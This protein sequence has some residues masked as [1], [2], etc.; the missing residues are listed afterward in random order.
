MA[1]SVRIAPSAGL[2]ILQRRG[3]CA[4]TIPATEPAPRPRR[5]VDS[6][7]WAGFAKRMCNE[8]VVD[9]V[10]G[11]WVW[12]RLGM[13][14]GGQVV[15][16]FDP[17]SPEVVNARQSISEHGKRWSGYPEREM[18]VTVLGPGGGAKLEIMRWGFPP[19]KMP[20]P[21]VTNVSDLDIRYWKPWLEPQRRC[22]VLVTAIA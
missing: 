7:G 5:N 8:Y 18:P 11:R 22:L 3:A 4:R 20:G 19:P 17:D 10:D 9:M 2:L 1:D 15:G 16:D 13:G 6:I 14:G 12:V 21:V